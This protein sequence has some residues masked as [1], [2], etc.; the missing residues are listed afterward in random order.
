MEN[1]HP[2]HQDDIKYLK[3]SLHEMENNIKTGMDEM[4]NKLNS[5]KAV[6]VQNNY[7]HLNPDPMNKQSSTDL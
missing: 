4:K 2:N 6:I 7:V 1:A 3:V 5:L